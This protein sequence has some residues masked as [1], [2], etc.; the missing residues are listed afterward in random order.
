VAE[1]LKLRNLLAEF[2]P[3]GWDQPQPQFTN[4]ADRFRSGLGSLAKQTRAESAPGALFNNERLLEEFR[5]G[6][7]RVALVG[8]R[9][10]IFSEDSGALAEFAAATERSFG[11]TVQRVMHYPGELMWHNMAITA[12]VGER[13]PSDLEQLA[14]CQ[15]NMPFRWRTLS[16]AFWLWQLLLCNLDAVRLRLMC[17]S[18]CLTCSK[19]PAAVDGCRLCRSLPLPLWPS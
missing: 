2:L 16:D 7:G 14:H 3:H 13:V 10:W 6:K 5:K 8:F 9:E 17:C 18:C 4:L 1:G 15:S 12:T 19:S 11:T